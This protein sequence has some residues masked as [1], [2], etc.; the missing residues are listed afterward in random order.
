MGKKIVLGPKAYPSKEQTQAIEIGH[1]KPSE[2]SISES[3]YLEFFGFLKELH[4]TPIEE[5]AQ[6]SHLSSS[7]S[8]I[9]SSL[10]NFFNHAKGYTSRQLEC[11]TI[12]L[13][14]LFNA[15]SDKLDELTFSREFILKLRR[16]T[17]D[18]A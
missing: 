17:S 4:L 15:I 2:F 16:F 1:K 7:L 5:K 3:K 18:L 13:A 6:K 10:M 9:T 14:N 11:S 8:F 12:C